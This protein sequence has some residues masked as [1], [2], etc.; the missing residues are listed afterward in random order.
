[1]SNCA[2]VGRPSGGK[3]DVL[4]PIS[5]SA[6]PD[7]NTLNFKE[8]KITILFNEYIKLKELNKQL[9]I[10]PPMKYS[11]EI[12]PQGYP[13]KKITIKIKDTLKESTTYTF[14]FGNAIIDNSEGNPLKRFKYLF[15]TGDYIDSLYTSGTVKDAFSDKDLK[16]ISVM[17]YLTDSTYSDSIIY[18]KKP[19]YVT[20]TL[21]SIGYLIENIKEGN[22]HIF[23]LNDTNHNLLFDSKS[24]KIAFIKEPFLVK[25][26]TSFNLILFQEKPEFAVKGVSEL[27]KNH[28]I[29][30]FVGAYSDFIKN[31][32]D[33]SNKT[34]DFITYKDRQTDTIHVWHRNVETDS[35]FISIKQ[36]DSVYKKIQRLRSKEID[37]IRLSKSI[38]QVLEPLDSFFIISNTPISKF[39]KKKIQFIDKDSLPVSFEITKKGK[40]GRLL[41]NF[42]QKEDYK[43]SLL[44]LPEAVT[45]YFGQK[46]D[47]ITFSFK[48]KKLDAYGEI[49]LNLDKPDTPIVIELLNDFGKVVRRQFDAGK[50]VKFKHLKPGKYKVRAIFDSNN[51][52]QWDT[53]NYLKKRQ[54]EKVIYY[55]KAIDLRAKWT[56]SEKFILK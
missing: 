52:H 18:K 46:N 4:P 47:S 50:E 53:G 56:I 21:D 13:A 39:D 36:Q 1:M 38:S 3:K 11:P 48:T 51:N 24:E 42:S 5:I 34:I 35:L 54:A 2:R 40:E 33:K 6:S 45:D 31:I 22:Y 29:V 44:L 28:L 26:D 41:I 10:S 8:E 32:T 17:L 20:N 43:Y 15:S 55:K 16:N 27:S 9:I 25:K 14:N 19:N 7:F 12:S 37:S 23:A 30:G 49:V